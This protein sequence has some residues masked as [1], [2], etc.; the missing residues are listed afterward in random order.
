MNDTTAKRADE[1]VTGDQIEQGRVTGPFRRYARDARGYGSVGIDGK[2]VKMFC[3]EAVTL[4]PQHVDSL[5]VEI[6]VGDVVRVLAWGAPVRLYDVGR[7][8]S[9]AGFTRAGNVVLEGQGFGDPIAN[10]RAVSPGMLGVLRR[11]G[12]TNGYEGNLDLYAGT[13]A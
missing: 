5:G 11:D 7:H 8:D 6:K 10:G 4:V 1:L 13:G 12:L 2:R 9:V 3:A